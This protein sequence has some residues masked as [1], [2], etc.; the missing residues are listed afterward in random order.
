ME[1]L[2]GVLLLFFLVEHLLSN[3]MLLLPTPDYYLAY[4]DFMGR[5]WF[6]RLLE[7]VLAAL[8]ITHIGVGARMRFNAWRIRRKRP[9]TPPPRSLTTRF[10]G[11]TGAV[12]LVFLLMH[13]SRF[14][15]P[16]RLGRAAS[17]LYNDAHI[18]F[19]SMWYTAFY[20][21]SMAAL[22]MHLFH[23][24]G[25]AV[26]SFPSLPRERIPVLRTWARWTAVVV[27]AG[28]AFIAV[29]LH[30]RSLLALTS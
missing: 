17:N 9:G 2:T 12:I 14:V 30:V 21:V 19:S 28:L 3:A 15:L 7:V 1:A 18:A 26:V 13:L 16:H 22:G 11:L 5:H 10:V 25:S 6:V 29:V 20:V 23:G 8:F 27:S 24:I 4:V